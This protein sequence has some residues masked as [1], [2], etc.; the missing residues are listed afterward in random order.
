VEE[1]RTLKPH[2][3]KVFDGQK[4]WT[5]EEILEHLK[6]D[7]QKCKI[8]LGDFGV[9][10]SQEGCASITLV[11]GIRIEKSDSKSG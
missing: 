8:E 1:N 6:F 11:H 5:G 4:T 7:P 2:Q 9:H 3:F 10:I